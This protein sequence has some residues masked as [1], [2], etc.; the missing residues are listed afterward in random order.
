[1][2]IIFLV[3]F[4]SIYTFKTYAKCNLKNS[5]DILEL[6]KKNHPSIT[7]N[8]VKGMALESNIEVAGQRLNPELDAESTVGD[9]VGGKNYRTSVSLKHTFE[10]GGKRDSRINVARNTFKT[11]VALAEFDNQQTIINTVIKL[12]RLRQVYEL[13][14]IYEESLS[15]F[16]K[17]LKTIKGRMS[18]S[19]EQQVE[20]ETLELAVNDYKL[21]IAQL[22]SEKM[23]LTTHLS[24]FMGVDC[25]IPRSALPVSINLD[26]RFERDLKIE[27]YS[28]FKA[29]TFSLEM[30]KSNLDLEKSNSYPDLQVG[31]IYEYEKNSAGRID[32]FGVAI[33]MDLPILSINSGGRK[34]ATNDVLAASLNLRNIKK[35]SMLDV[36]SWLQKYNQYKDSLKTIANKDKLEKKHRKIESLFNRGIISTS[37]VIESHRQLVE[38]FITRFEF[39][40]GAT[41]ALWNIYKLNGEIASKS[42]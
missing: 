24:F 28:K 7:F 40:I 2:K 33:T 42:L 36:Q 11:G 22:N 14:P 31:P 17:I 20:A 26:E 35:E 39:E 29:A 16:N 10:L 5:N 38:F 3:V 8:N 41:E 27:N 1:M 21:K 9:S 15:A 30:A 4:I 34:R 13:V 12:H 37:L 18:L 23:N 25:T 32:T 19:P 6:V